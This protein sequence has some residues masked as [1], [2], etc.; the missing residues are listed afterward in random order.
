MLAVWA[1][2]GFVYPL[3]ETRLR[4]GQQTLPSRELAHVVEDTLYGLIVTGW[5]FFSMWL[6][7]KCSTCVL[8]RTKRTCCCCGGLWTLLCG[9]YDQKDE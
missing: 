4:T 7:M 1:I 3:V 8:G 9:R 5:V 2:M 6:W